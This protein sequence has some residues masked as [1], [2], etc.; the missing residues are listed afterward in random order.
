MEDTMP[1]PREAK[2]AA[3]PFLDRATGFKGF[4]LRTVGR[5][6]AIP[7]PAFSKGRVFFGGGFGTY[8]VYAVDAANGAP[9]WQLRTTDDGPTA[10]TLSGGFA[11]YNT[12][13]CT[14]EV[15]DAATGERRWNR[16]LGDP[17]LGQPAVAVDQ[18]FM[19][20]PK[21]GQHILG[22]F[23]LSD[24]RPIWET[25]LGHDVISAPIVAGTNVYVSTFDGHVACFDRRSGRM[26][27][28]RDMLATSAPWIVGDDVY[29]AERVA[30]D[31]GA[32]NA[33]REPKD[34]TN[35][36]QTEMLGSVSPLERTA[37]L[38]AR[39]GHGKPAF[40]AKPAPYYD[41]SWAAHAKFAAAGFDAAVGFSTPPSASKIDKVRATIG[42]GTISRAWRHQGSRPV[43]VDGVLYETTGDRL[44]ARCLS[45]GVLLW[46]WGEAQ[47]R[48]GNRALT[49]PAVANGRVLA[50]SAD[51][52]IIQWD[53]RTGAVRFEVAVGAPVHWMPVMA[54]GHIA[55]G[56]EDGSIVSFATGDPANDGWPM[57][58]GG[59]GHNGPEAPPSHVRATATSE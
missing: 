39:I 44:E 18:L 58:G 35:D 32:S 29:V 21:A 38:D 37:N 54:D 17:L 31:R 11:A 25:E 30:S 22:A 49:P 59:P 15:V 7:T 56:L 34:S 53:A 2:L 28:Q 27:W 5:N 57:W 19:A 55:A 46:S 14:V 42:E 20:W 50:G 3:E 45:S 43:V 4:R 23:A 40:R 48:D 8:E 47:A 9:I 52:R 10:M 51:G 12:E 6:A 1:D 16:W 33:Q 36:A 13:S 26:L 41:A 24:G